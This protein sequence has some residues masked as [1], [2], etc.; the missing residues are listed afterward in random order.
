MGNK[1]AVGHAVMPKEPC[2]PSRVPSRSVGG[3]GWLSEGRCGAQAEVQDLAV[4]VL[5]FGTVAVHKQMP[6]RCQTGG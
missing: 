6:W 2:Y 1:Q 3:G 4:V 5:V